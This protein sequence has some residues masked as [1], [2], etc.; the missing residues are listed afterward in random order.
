MAKTKIDKR[1][2]ASTRPHRSAGPRT[3]AKAT[4]HTGTKVHRAAEH[5]EHADRR[6]RAQPTGRVFLLSPANCNGPRAKI[7]LSPRAT[8]DLAVRLRSDGGVAL[9]EVFAFVSGLYFKGKLA[10]ALTF[11]RP[12]EPGAPIAGSGVLV[13]TPNAGL[14]PAETRVTGD[15][16]HGFA[17]VDIAANDPRYRA[18]L[19]ASA[20]ARR[21]NR[22]RVRGRAARQH[23]V[24]EVRRHPD[25]GLRRAP[26]F[27]IDFVGRGDMSRGGLML[28]AARER[29]GADLCARRRRRPPRSAPPQTGAAA[30]NLDDRVQD[31]RR[32]LMSVR[33]SSAR[34]SASGSEFGVRS[35][36]RVKIRRSRSSSEVELRGPSRARR[37][38]PP[39]CCPKHAPDIEPRTRNQPRTPEPRTPNRLIPPSPAP[40]QVSSAA[41]ARQKST[42]RSYRSPGAR[43]R[44]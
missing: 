43:L 34:G 39:V 19:L 40:P 1:K 33:G 27:P 24:G 18:P 16:L 25:G 32:Q 8:F 26:A 14:R 3:A 15:A 13:I 29:R 41:P 28:R 37:T 38:S 5:A 9:G 4:E 23:R 11:A 30:G 7:V 42:I 21:G 17:G 31:E 22:R 6:V 35:A 2:R 20:R 36:A 44:R 12:P 10:Y